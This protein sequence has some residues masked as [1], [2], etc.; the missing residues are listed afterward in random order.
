MNK[1][2]T[3]K[4]FTLIELLIVIG[5]LAILATVTL[6]V[7]NPAQMFAQAR[8]SQRISDLNT[9]KSAL[10]LYVSTATTPSLGSSDTV[11]WGTRATTSVGTLAYRLFADRNKATFLGATA[12]TSVGTS[13]WIPVAFAD[14]TGGSPISVLPFDPTSFDVATN[15]NTNAV[16]AYYYTASSTGVVFELDAN[17]E[18]ARYIQ[19]GPD[20]KESTDG[21]DRAYMYEVGTAVNL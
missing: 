10:A 13:G 17:L 6:L 21:G 14:T 12:T 19:S 8:D 5:L 3:K 15:S 4:G 7:I 9:L 1:I 20:D 11:I 18:S 16:Y 2:N